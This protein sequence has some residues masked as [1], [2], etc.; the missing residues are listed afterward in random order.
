MTSDITDNTKGWREEVRHLLGLSWDR[1]VEWTVIAWLS[2]WIWTAWAVSNAVVFPAS[3]PI[4]WLAEVVR[5]LG[6]E[7]AS[8]LTAIPV[9][10]TEPQRSVLLP[11]SVVASA[12]F[13]TLSVRSY[14][15][16]GLRVLA[17]IAAVVAVEIHG[18]ALPLIWVVLV[19]AVPFG[20]AFGL[21]FLPNSDELDPREWSRHYPPGA[22]QRFVMRVVGLYAMPV[23]APVLLFPAL[24]SSYRVER[25]YVPSEALAEAAARELGKES[26]GERP[27]ASA[28]PI[29]MASSIV[30]A[31]TAT[32][33]TASSREVAAAFDHHIREGRQSPLG[34]WRT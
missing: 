5:L 11:I 29:A 8:W 6:G 30:A 18:S 28:D 20:V 3:G 31:I 14:R 7:P 25:K 23:A 26:S 12:S 27:H 9:W 19:A 34:G 15:L 32:S 1:F 22:L 24:V 2:A 16:T 33:A 10:L 13:A 21:G 17:L 4:T